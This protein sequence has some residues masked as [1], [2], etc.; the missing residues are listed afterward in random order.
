[1]RRV[2]L[3]AGVAA[4]SLLAAGCASSATGASNS[5]SSPVVLRLGFLA[6]I[7]HEPALVGIAKGY[8]TKD[9]GKN[10]T[11]KTS[12]FSTG[13]E[14]TT[15]LLAGQLDA[16][17]VGPNPAINAW[18]KSNGTAIK[19]ISG[20]ASGGASLV[21]KKGITSA[22]QLKGKSLA[23]P[24]LG[25]TQDVALRF[26]LKQ[27]G[28]ATTPTGGGDLS[29]KPIKPNSAAV[30]EFA[31]G[32]I[33][34]GWEP[35]PYATEM[36]L[37]GGTRLV[38]E[39]SLW[40]GGNFV[41]TN[42]VVTQSFLKDHPSTV[43]G[44]LKGQIEANSYIN[45]NSTAAASAANAELTKLL[46]KGLKP[47]VLSRGA[48]VHPLHQRP[49]RV[50]AG[51]RCPA[52]GGRG[53]AHAGEEPARHLRPRPAQR[54]AEGG[55]T[56]T[57]EP[58]SLD[59]RQAAPPGLLPGASARSGAVTNDAL[60]GADG[61][62]AISISEVSK[63]FGHGKTTLH[64]LDRVSLDVALGEFVCLIGASGCGKS[65]LLSLVAGLDTPTAGMID[66][67]GRKVALMFQEPALFPWLTAAKNVELALRPSGMTAKAR[68]EPGRGTAGSGAPRT[69]SAT[70]GR[71][72]CPAACASGWRWPGRWPPTPTCCS[73]TSRSAPWTP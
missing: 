48:A 6:N 16:A 8:F 50:V 36:V 35:E 3:T 33:D 30:L 34:G 9:L 38:N 59:Q 49:H 73:W 45:S 64:A 15:A 2:L 1:M 44:L 24:S 11:L 63:A 69:A 60:N 20:A 37:D 66:T 47:N 25:N 57:G 31:S 56:T 68:R 71:T 21:V 26:W 12:V 19:I 72:S 18:Q 10:V 14:E 17:Y 27:H 65:T 52:R 40:P 23:T 41:T 43:N 22:A 7:T 51:H 28:L 29:I 42:L 67:S 4:V 13:T 61:T 62:T 54:T 55:R 53:P 5:G 32:Q 46:G 58:M 39:A 70:S